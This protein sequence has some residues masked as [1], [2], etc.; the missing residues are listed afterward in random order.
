MRNLREPGFA[1]VVESLLAASGLPA[2]TLTLEIPEGTV[3]LEPERSLE[4]LRHFRN[5]GIG[6][7][8]DDFGTGYSSLGYLSRLPVDEIKID[9]SFVME[10]A[11]PG[12]RAIVESVIGLGRAFDL[13]VVAEGVKDRP[14]LDA[15]VALSC[16]VAQGYHYS[17]P[18][19]PPAFADWLQR[20]RVGV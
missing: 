19:A 1:D 15:L 16:P 12:N 4:V 20:H 8:I 7:A 2:S 17:A 5:Q 9:K 6:V 10:L 11:E 13:R 14:T 18:V 3:M